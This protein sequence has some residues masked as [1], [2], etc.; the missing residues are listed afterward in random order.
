[1]PI[2]VSEFFTKKIINF[3]NYFKFSSILSNICHRK[4]FS[5]VGQLLHFCFLLHYNCICML[6]NVF[7]KI[8]TKINF[9]IFPMNFPYF[10]RNMSYEIFSFIRKCLHFLFNYLIFLFEGL[11]LYVR[12]FQKKSSIL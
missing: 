5:F 7:V 1:M 10:I 8:T 12:F 6:T 9:Q 3:I 2:I 4:I 11:S